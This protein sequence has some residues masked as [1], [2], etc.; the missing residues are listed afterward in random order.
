MINYVVIYLYPNTL[1]PFP[2][3]NMSS[4]SQKLQTAVFLYG[5][6]QPSLKFCELL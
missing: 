2:Y 1:G 6:L 3:E 5:L 4:G